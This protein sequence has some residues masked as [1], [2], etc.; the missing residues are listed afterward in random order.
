MGNDGDKMLAEAE[1]EMNAASWM[2]IGEHKSRA[3]LQQTAKKI[4]SKWAGRYD[5]QICRCPDKS[6]FELRLKHR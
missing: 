5:F 1:E 3:T 6:A 4:R 2:K